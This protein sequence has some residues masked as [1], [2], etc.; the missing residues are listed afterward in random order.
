MEI[1]AWGCKTCLKFDWVHVK[2]AMA[3]PEHVPHR[4]FDIGNCPG[5]M[6][7]LYEAAKNR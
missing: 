5:K 4:G 6:I 3:K 7:L 2:E 1:V